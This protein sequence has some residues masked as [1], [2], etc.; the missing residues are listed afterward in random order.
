MVFS[1]LEFLF[2]FL[3][4]FMLIYLIVHAKYRNI[5]LLS[6]SLICSAAYFICS[7]ELWIEQ[8]YVLGAAFSP[9]GS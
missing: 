1:S 7:R 5:V 3:P 2:R 9:A 4:V 6:G 8:I